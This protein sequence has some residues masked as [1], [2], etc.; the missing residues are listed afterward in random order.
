MEVIQ[1]LVKSGIVAT[2]VLLCDSSQVNHL[3]PCRVAVLSLGLEERR[4]RRE[5]EEE[6]EGEGEKD[7]QECG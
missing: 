3:L 4:W 2:S 5:G 1:E 6:E 7:S